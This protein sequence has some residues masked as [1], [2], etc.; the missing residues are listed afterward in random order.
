MRAELPIHAV[1][2]QRMVDCDVSGI[3]FTSNPLQQ[4][5]DRM[6]IT[7]AQGLGEGIVSGIVP[8]DEYT[9]DKTSLDEAQETILGRQNIKVALGEDGGTKIVPMIHRNT[10]PVLFH[11]AIYRLAQIAKA[12]DSHFQ[13]SRDIEWGIKINK[14]GERAI[15]VFQARP[16]TTRINTNL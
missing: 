12:I 13:E 3:I 15:Y 7:A 5:Q 1:L 10:Q 16:I 2:L 8:A 14:G 9:A 11:C 6:V 4:D